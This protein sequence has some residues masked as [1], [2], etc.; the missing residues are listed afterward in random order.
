MTG[1]AVLSST[2]ARALTDQIKVGVEAVWQ[3]ITR[4]YTER[5]W[6]ALGYTSWDDYCTREFGQSRLRLPREERAEIVS[7]LRESG[8]S[9]RAIASATGIGRGTVERELLPVPTGTRESE[10]VAAEP[11]A[12]A[13]AEQLVEAEPVAPIVG[14]DG[15]RYRRQQPA[16]P[17]TTPVTPVVRRRKPITEVFWRAKHDL[18]KVADRITRL[19]DDDRFGKNRGQLADVNLGD[20][21]RIRAAINGVIEAL[22]GDMYPGGTR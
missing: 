10:S 6:D 1:D 18:S 12:D 8:L 21:I 15:K 17:K 7:S 13:L 2:D 19:A 9:I 5:A 11:D 4:A 20:L 16:A 14:I 3:L 22:G